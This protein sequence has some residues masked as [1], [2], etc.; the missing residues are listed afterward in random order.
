[1]K[2]TALSEV[3]SLSLVQWNAIHTICNSQ[4]Q[5]MSIYRQRIKELEDKLSL[6]DQSEIEALYER[7][8]QLTNMIEELTK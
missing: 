5:Q 6:V 1:M 4:E 7:N 8:Q 3:R 2:K